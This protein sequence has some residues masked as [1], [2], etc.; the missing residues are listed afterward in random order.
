MMVY[1]ES[2]VFDTGAGSDQLLGPPTRRMSASA[3]G[4]LG[5]GRRKDRSESRDRAKPEPEAAALVLGNFQGVVVIDMG[6]VMVR[7]AGQQQ[8][9]ISAVRILRS[10]TIVLVAGCWYNSSTAALQLTAVRIGSSFWC[11]CCRW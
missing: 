9:H 4:P 5:Y 1:G 6:F 2:S 7:T 10:A 11:R 8:Y 3:D